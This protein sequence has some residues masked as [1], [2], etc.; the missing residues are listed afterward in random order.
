MKKNRICRDYKAYTRFGNE[1]VYE[2][3]GKKG[4]KQNKEDLSNALKRTYGKYIT[5][6]DVTFI[7]RWDG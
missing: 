7:E 2:S 4:S 6:K 3:Y 1:V 5:L